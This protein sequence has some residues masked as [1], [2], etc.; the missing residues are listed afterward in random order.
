M[1]AQPVIA[2]A[3]IAVLLSTSNSFAQPDAPKP[4]P[5]QTA[6]RQSLE[7]LQNSASEYTAQRKCFSC[8]HQAVPV[9]AFTTAKK[10][11]F[12]IDDKELQRQIQFTADFLAKNRD[13]YEKGKGQG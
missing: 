4:D 9:L 10:R 3:L 13:N 7:L 11:G 2:A 5:V 8:H 6:V 12:D 1:R